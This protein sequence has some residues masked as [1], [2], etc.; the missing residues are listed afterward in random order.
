M[1]PNDGRSDSQIGN[2]T[3][4]VLRDLQDL[5][6]QG[7]DLLS[8]V[9]AL[10][11]Q[12][13]ARQIAERP[14]KAEEQVK[15]IFQEKELIYEDETAFVYRRGDTKTRP[16]YIRINDSKADKPFIAS[17]GT[18]NRHVAISKAMEIYKNV[19]GKIAR[20]EKIKAITTKELF[21]RYLNQIQ[22]KLTMTPHEGI[23][24]ETYRVKKYLLNQ[25]LKFIDENG[26]SETPIDQI[27]PE[28][29]RHFSIW[30]SNQPKNDGTARSREHINKIGVEVI[31]AYKEVAVRER[32]IGQ[33]QI[34]E[35]DKIKIRQNDGYKR[36]ILTEE[37][38]DELR[39]YLQ[40]WADSDELDEKEAI[41]RLIFGCTVNILYSTGMRVKELLSLR[42]NDIRALENEIENGCIIRI[43]GENSKTGRGRNVPSNC[44]N[45]INGIKKGYELLEVVHQSNDLL[46]FNPDS[47]QRKAY[48]RQ[49]L[50]HRLRIALKES[51]LKLKLEQDGRTKISLYSSRHYFITRQLEKG[52]DKNFLSKVVG[53]GIKNI[54]NVYGQI[55]VIRNASKITDQLEEFRNWQARMLNNAMS[56]FDT[57][58]K[59]NIKEKPPSVRLD[60][61]KV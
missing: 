20:G 51:G 35:I 36:D 58:R 15:S 57:K 11:T 60:G 39:Q 23:V 30:M 45:F 34:P 2:K 16:Y 22:S 32:F 50:D 12:Q 25:W 31:K 1:T 13:E 59:Y 44:M 10:Q 38:W 43:K 29:T 5:S 53:T 19:K 27:K 33:Y 21:E 61:M 55:D 17:L 24:P 18:T 42:L 47:N 14:L 8:L 41:K 28:S 48:T 52:V 4:Q 49:A 37:E 54:E 46:L 40:C 26:W 9:S 56:E 6:E 3:L 7:V